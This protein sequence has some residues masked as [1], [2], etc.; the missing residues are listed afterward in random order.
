MEVSVIIVTYNQER[1]IG[2]T[3]QS[4][5]CQE[6]DFDWE[7]II[8]DDASTDGTS[9]ICRDYAARYPGKIR[10]R[11][12]ETNQGLVANYYSCVK[13]ALGRY[14]SDIGGDD[15]WT[16]R[17]KLERQARYLDTHPRC[18]LVHTAY[19]RYIHPSGTIEIP[20]FRDADNTTFLSLLQR[21][22]KAAVHLCTAMYRRKE[23]LE[24]YD[25]YPEIFNNPKMV[26]EDFQL[27]L[28]LA[29]MGTIDWMPDNTLCYRVHEDSLSNSGD[30][31]KEFRMYMCTLAVMRHMQLRHSVSDGAMTDAYTELARYILALVAR[32]RSPRMLALAESVFTD[33]PLSL[34]LKARLRR[35]LL[36]M[37]IYR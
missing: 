25:L 34:P 23:A 19:S 9:D 13:L 8:G 35:M 30:P 11:R 3:L 12:N 16:D 21:Q 17:H 10:Y 14:I 2:Q 27:V 28:G 6:C 26:F 32:A 1:F 31:H 5:L 15:F 20:D 29:A 4:V 7:I 36:H 24:C 37:H 33:L 18:M 22:R